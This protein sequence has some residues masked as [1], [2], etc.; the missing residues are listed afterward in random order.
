MTYFQFLDLQISEQLI[1]EDE[2]VLARLAALV[3]G[4][5]E[6][7]NQTREFTEVGVN[8]LN[9]ALAVIAEI[10]V[11]EEPNLAVLIESD[12]PTGT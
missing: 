5:C 12:N 9:H 3:P 1:L 10:A 11:A 2:I 6:A 4:L 8:A 7:L